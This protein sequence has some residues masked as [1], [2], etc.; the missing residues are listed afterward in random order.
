MSGKGR[1]LLRGEEL[2]EETQ[3]NEAAQRM[4]SATEEGEK[5]ESDDVAKVH[6]GKREGSRE[7]I[8]GSRAEQGGERVRGSKEEGRRRSRREREPQVWGRPGGDRSVGVILKL[9]PVHDEE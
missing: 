8:L 6:G 1:S 4:G 3:A 2:Q 5:Q 9:Q 7:P